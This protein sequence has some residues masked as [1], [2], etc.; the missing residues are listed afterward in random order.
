[1]YFIFISNALHLPV[2]D[3]DKDAIVGVHK[4]V[5]MGTSQ[6][7]VGCA[8]QR[9]GFNAQMPDGD[10]KARFGW[11]WNVKT[12]ACED[13]DG[14]SDGCIGIGLKSQAQTKYNG[15]NRGLG[16]G[17]GWTVHVTGT[18]NGRVPAWVYV[19]LKVCTCA[20]G[21]AATGDAC[22]AHNQ[23]ICV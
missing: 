8:M 21:E 23:E 10:H 4:D 1:M 7:E 17:A 16:V 14:D 12:Q 6:Y 11:C 5:G 22:L 3:L 20:D 2:P 19:S 15:V 13:D 18:H 9:P